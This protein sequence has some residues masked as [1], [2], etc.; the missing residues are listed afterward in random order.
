MD[1]AEGARR[2]DV[3]G[4]RLGLGDLVADGEVAGE[5]AEADEVVEVVAVEQ[6]L[7]GLLDA[8]AAAVGGGQGARPGAAEAGD[9][10]PRPAPGA[11]RAG[12]QDELAVAWEGT[13]PAANRRANRPTQLDGDTR[14]ERLVAQPRHDRARLCRQAPRP[15]RVAGMREEATDG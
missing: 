4:P 7:D 14:G 6:L 1:G 11:G 10:D 2:A 3:R 8:P 5:E 15:T 9:V 13:R 12:A